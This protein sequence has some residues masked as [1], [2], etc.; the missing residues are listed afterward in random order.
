MEIKEF[1]EK[2]ETEYSEFYVKH[3]LKEEKLANGRTEHKS[4]FYMYRSRL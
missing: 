2:S 1:Q 4:T 3:Y